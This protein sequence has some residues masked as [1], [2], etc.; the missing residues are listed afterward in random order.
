MRL[1][2]SPPIALDLSGA[3]DDALAVLS[4]LQL[5]ACLRTIL[6]GV[7]EPERREMQSTILAFTA[8][9]V[10]TWRPAL[11]RD[12][13]LIA[14]IEAFLK[15]TRRRTGE[16]AVLASLMMRVDQAFLAEEYARVRAGYERLLPRVLSWGFRFPEDDFNIPAHQLGARYLVAIYMTAPLAV[17]AQAIWWA[18]A[19]LPASCVN[20][21]LR[22]LLHAALKP[23]PEWD[24]FVRPWASWLATPVWDRMF[25]G[26]ALPGEDDRLIE[27]TRH[28]EGVAGLE[29]LAGEL[30]TAAVHSTWA[31]CLIADERWPEVV[32]VLQRAAEQSGSPADRQQFWSLAARAAIRVG[33]R[34]AQRHALT[35][36]W[37][38]RPCLQHML[39]VLGVDEPDAGAVAA[40]VRQELTNGMD[41]GP[42]LAAVMYLLMGDYPR[43]LAA[44]QQD[45]PM[46]G[47]V[48]HLLGNLV[49]P[50][51]FAQLRGA[52]PLGP[53]SE[54]L[55]SLL[56]AVASPR[57]EEKAP[58]HAVPL[59]GL[60]ALP[61][62]TLGPFLTRARE[63]Y[64][65]S[66]PQRFVLRASYQQAMLVVLEDILEYGQTIGYEH[67]ALLLAAYIELAA[68]DETQEGTDVLARVAGFRRPMAFRKALKRWLGADPWEP[69][70]K[71]RGRAAAN[72]SH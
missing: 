51:V 8:R 7:P 12:D 58:C 23:L 31:E 2:S 34:A 57:P 16:P 62:V 3:V 41:G 56:F 5:A 25:H 36:A 24:A 35:Q 60:S 27:A 15:E 71:T 72:L 67:G 28:A 14:A 52:R 64:P 50:A 44:F 48:F 45:P 69:G 53:A 68:A 37:R 30:G 32:R 42:T 65:V 21:P 11:A 17:R 54:A 9:H 55:C 6:A 1:P 61:G 63:K 70:R 49:G 47:W 46:Q 19:G 18:L 4:Q 22:T 26:Q 59:T 20:Q 29:R 43:A 10:P 13:E 66:E 40:W 39:D 33:D 38:E